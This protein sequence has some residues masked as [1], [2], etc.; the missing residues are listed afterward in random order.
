MKEHVSIEQTMRKVDYSRR[1]KVINTNEVIDRNDI[2]EEN[3]FEYELLFNHQ[4]KNMLL[5]GGFEFSKPQYKSDR[6]TGGNQ[7]KDILGVFNQ[8][9][10]NLSSVMDI[11][12]GIR[13]DNYNDTT[14]FSPRL[15][16][17]YKPNIQWT[18]RTSYGHGFRAPSF[19]ESLIDWEHVEFGY[20]VKGNP[21]LKPEVSKGITLGAEYRN[22][23]NFQFSSLFYHNSFSN[24]IKDYTLESGV[25]SYRNIESADFTGIELIAKWIINN[26]LT[27]TVSVNYLKN[28]DSNGNPIPNTMPL[29]FGGRLSYSPGNQKLLI[30]LSLKGVGE[31]SPLEY[32]PLSGDYISSSTIV[33]P[34]LVGDLQITYRLN[35]KYKILIG[36]KNIGNH[37][38]MAFGP[39]I[40]RTAYIEINTNIERK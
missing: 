10:F 2:T 3:N 35:P 22:N 30:A 29:S 13:L 37:I 19:M 24:L 9:T 38:N 14:V 16:F 8:A 36:S 4:M 25:F 20:S 33:D 23:N 32:D 6:I 1:Y 21:D 7:T 34:Y 28:Q 39:Y 18:F 26:S 27:S 12:A 11:V 31:Y 40:G 5:N 15:A 17:A